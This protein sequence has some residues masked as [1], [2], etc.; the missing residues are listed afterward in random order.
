MLD[1]GGG[2]VGEGIPLSLHLSELVMGARGRKL[3]GVSQRRDHGA[4]SNI[5]VVRITVELDGGHKSTSTVH[6]RVQAFDVGENRRKSGNNCFLG[7]KCKEPNVIGKI[8]DYTKHVFGSPRSGLFEW[9]KDVIVDGLKGSCRLSAGLSI[10]D[11]MA[12][13]V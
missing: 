11:G 9:A 1:H 3:G 2:R 8:I 13:F 5:K 12:Q 6:A 7:W 10:D 4:A